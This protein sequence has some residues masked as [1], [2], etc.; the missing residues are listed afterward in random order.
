MTYKKKSNRMNALYVHSKDNKVYL[1][2]DN[3]ANE[4]INFQWIPIMELNKN[5]NQ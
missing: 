4:P 2:M 3:E 5:M 1:R